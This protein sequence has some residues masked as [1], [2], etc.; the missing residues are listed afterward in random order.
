MKNTIRI[1]E[2]T[3][4]VHNVVEDFLREELKKVILENSN[5]GWEQISLQDVFGF[6][7]NQLPPIYKLRSEETSLMLDKGE[8]RNAIYLAMEKVKQNPLSPIK[9]FL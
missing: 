8:I 1:N 2:W 4:S 7:I 6:A 9:E 3:K 5:W